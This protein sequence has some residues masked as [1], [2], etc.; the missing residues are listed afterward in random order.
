V[1]YRWPLV[2]VILAPTAFNTASLGKTAYGG[3]H[4]YRY[5]NRSICDDLDEDGSAILAP[6]RMVSRSRFWALWGR[7]HELHNSFASSNTAI[8]LAVPHSDTLHR[9][10]NFIAHKWMQG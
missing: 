8:N 7:H 1:V 3:L 9:T 2:G 4:R 6:I 5:C 10:S